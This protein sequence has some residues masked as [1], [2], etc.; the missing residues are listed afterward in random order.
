MKET[1]NAKTEGL[2]GTNENTGPESNHRPVKVRKHKLSQN[3]SLIPVMLVTLLMMVGY[4]ALSQFILSVPVAIPLAIA[5]DLKDMTPLTSICSCVCGILML[6]FFYWWFRPEF[7]WKPR[8]TAF[9]FKA[10]APILLYWFVYY[11]VLFT[12]AAGHL[13]FG[14]EKVTFGSIVFAASAGICE[15][16]AFREVG[17]SY[18]KRQL[19]GDQWKILIILFT[20]V[21]FGV[22]HLSNAISG[23]APLWARMIQV[24]GTLFLGIFF[25]SL[26]LRT[27]NIWVCIL[28]HTVYDMLPEF[29]LSKMDAELTVYIWGW[30][31]VG[32]ALLAAWGLYLVRKEK[33]P[34]INALWNDKWQVPENT[35]A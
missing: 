1:L 21:I 7:Q 12:A 3:H 5:L 22:S 31:L 34:E 20:S 35:E 11:V 9:A 8:N 6:F 4:Y 13:T 29:F 32:Q 30:M 19:R 24:F 16:M 10:A 18:F 17:I 33:H 28:I 23:N 27:G 2:T 14:L 26:F 25:G 15:E